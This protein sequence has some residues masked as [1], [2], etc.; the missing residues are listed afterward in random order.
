MLELFTSLWG[1]MRAGGWV[2]WPLLA[3][4][5]VAVT[6]SSERLAFWASTHRPRRLVTIE[7]IAREVRDG[8]L[9]KALKRARRDRSVYGRYLAA[10]IERTTARASAGTPLHESFA[11]E[12]AERLRPAVERFS[13]TLSTIITAAPMLGILGTVTGIIKSFRLIGQAGIVTDPTSIAA[14]I[15]E[16]LFTTAFGLV[17]ALV[18]LFPHAMFRAQSERCLARL[19]VIAA[20]LIEATRPERLAQRP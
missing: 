5:L 9:D 13:A 15:G 10:L 3:L 2:M 8:Q 18:T 11:H 16:A 20:T 7:A 1:L 14:G 12:Q 17:V 6:L 19:E 4:S